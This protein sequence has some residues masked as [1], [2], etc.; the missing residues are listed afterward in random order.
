MSNTQVKRHDGHKHGGEPQ[1][2]K[3][4]DML[5]Y[6]VAVAA[7]ILALV[8]VPKALGAVGVSFLADGSGLNKLLT[9]LIAGGLGWVCLLPSQSYK[10]F[11]ALSKGARIEWRKTIK[12]DR[13]TVMRTTMMVLAL[14]AFF[15]LLI[16]I[17][18]WIFGSIL[19][20]MIA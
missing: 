11:V 2:G 12:P 8:F 4:S 20:W 7:V 9:F 15:A 5:F 16:L 1:A 10:N 13:D 18:D 14:V 17:L 3:K 6:I 19:S